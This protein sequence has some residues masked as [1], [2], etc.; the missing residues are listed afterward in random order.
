MITDATWDDP[1]PD[2][3]EYHRYF[4]LNDDRMSQTHTWVTADYPAATG[5]RYY[6]GVDNGR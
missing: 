5:T 4:G 6:L 2:G 1:I 3:N